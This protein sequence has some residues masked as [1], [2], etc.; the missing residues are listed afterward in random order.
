MSKNDKPQH[1]KF[2]SGPESWCFS[3]RELALGSK[4]PDHSSMK[5]IS[6]YLVYNILPVYHRLTSD[7]LSDNS[8]IS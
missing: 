2:P 5:I 1:Q 8:Q 6:Y 3:N 4:V 7:E